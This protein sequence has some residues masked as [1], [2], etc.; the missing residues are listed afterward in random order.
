MMACSHRERLLGFFTSLQ[1]SNTL[2]YELPEVID[3]GK[4]VTI[5]QMGTDYNTGTYLQ[6]TISHRNF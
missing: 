4:V 6:K 3:W 5:N 1:Q 2:I